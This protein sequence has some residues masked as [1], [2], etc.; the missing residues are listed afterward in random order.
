[1]VWWTTRTASVGQSCN[2]LESNSISQTTLPCPRVFTYASLKSHTSQGHRF[3]S[4]MFTMTGFLTLCKS[5]QNIF[6]LR[7]EFHL[8]PVAF[9]KAN[10][11]SGFTSNSR[12]GS[13]ELTARRCGL[14]RRTSHRSREKGPQGAR[15]PG[16]HTPASRH[17]T[18]STLSPPGLFAFRPPAL[19]ISSH[20][21]ND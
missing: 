14:H 4:K 6:G 7:K 12:H 1:M 20:L 5:K 15:L 2:L 18:L 11:P 9:S 16:H 13:S 21:R 10:N 8:S 3:F 17:P 19:N